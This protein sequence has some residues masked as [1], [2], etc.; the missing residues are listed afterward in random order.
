M[1][2]PYCRHSKSISSRKYQFHLCVHCT[3]LVTYEPVL[4]FNWQWGNPAGLGAVDFFA[5]RYSFTLQVPATGNY[6]F[7]L[8]AD[9]I[10]RMYIDKEW[11]GI[12][13]GG[14]QPTVMLQ[15]GYHAVQIEYMEWTGYSSFNLR[16][17]AGIANGVS[18]H[19]DGVVAIKQ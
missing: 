12:N 3:D 7:N 4:D 13:R 5:A 10:A 2:L 15:K 19:Q 16:W 18:G 14:Q 17:N 9:D 8:N 1:V 6:S 11:V